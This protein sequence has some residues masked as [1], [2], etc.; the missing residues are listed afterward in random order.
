MN[1][2]LIFALGLVMVVVVLAPSLDRLS[3]NATG[4]A[5]AG[6]GDGA[7]G[8]PHVTQSATPAAAPAG[9]GTAI[10]RDGNGQFHIQAMVNDQPVRMLIDTGADG[11][12]LSEADA[13]AIGMVPDPAMFTQPVTTA[14]GAAYGAHIRIDRLEVAGHDLGAM[15]AMV[16]HGLG[17]SLL[18][19]SALRRVGTV[20]MSGDRMVIGN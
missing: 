12:A 17:T 10:D 11:V 18:G 20:T 7:V 16:V 14:S 4:P 2:Y 13:R 6:I 9:S 3:G 1:R 19:Q 15:D 8:P 5:S